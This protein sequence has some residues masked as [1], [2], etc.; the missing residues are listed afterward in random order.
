MNI[1]TVFVT[2]KTE[3]N[4]TVGFVTYVAGETLCLFDID[5]LETYAKALN[6][7]LVHF[8]EMKRL[9]TVGECLLFSLNGTVLTSESD[10]EALW[11]DLRTTNRAHIVSF[12][13]QDGFFFD[14]ARKAW[15]VKDPIT[16]KLYRVAMQEVT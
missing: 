7:M 13:D 9:S 12:T 8:D 16:N 6:T 11:D 5:A 3:S 1:Q 10:F 15:C 2:N 4:I 14:M